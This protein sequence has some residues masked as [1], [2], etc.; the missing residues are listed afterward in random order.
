MY[1]CLVLV[2]EGRLWEFLGVW[3]GSFGAFLG[4][5][6]DRTVLSERSHTNIEREKLTCKLHFSLN[7]YRLFFLTIYL[8]R[9]LQF[10]GVHIALPSSS[11]PPLSPSYL[12][13]NPEDRRSSPSFPPSLHAGELATV[14]RSCRS[15]HAARARPLTSF[16]YT[17]GQELSLPAEGGRARA[18]L[19]SRVSSRSV[20]REQC[21]ASERRRA[22][23]KAT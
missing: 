2:R 23:T 7:Q 8:K 1:S 3:L 5:S 16:A 11:S 12:L 21:S 18:A 6:C 20:G 19:P 13:L 4:E 14:P 22:A 9:A 15:A 17:L 10:E